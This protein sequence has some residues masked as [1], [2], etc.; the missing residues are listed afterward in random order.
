MRIG[1]NFLAI[2]L[3]NGW[4]KVECPKHAGD[5]QEQAAFSNMHAGA[6]TTTSTKGE[7]VSFCSIRVNG[8]VVQGLKVILVPVRVKSLWVGE[9]FG[10]H[11]D[12]VDVVQNTGAL[13]DMIAHIL[14]IFRYCM[15]HYCFL[16]VRIWIVGVI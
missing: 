9:S 2:A 10:I 4:C 16:S 14:V 6:Y 13:W 12:C 11:V 5:A 8:R 7:R 3:I 15:R 1:G